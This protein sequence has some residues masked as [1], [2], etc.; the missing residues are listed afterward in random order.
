MFETH[1]VHLLVFAVLAWTRAYVAAKSFERDAD[2]DIDKFSLSA[3]TGTR[4][5]TLG[6][7]LCLLFDKWKYTLA[8]S[9][10]L[11]STTLSGRGLRYKGPKATQIQA[12]HNCTQ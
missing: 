11:P 2:E 5:Q 3:T 1:R 10:L 9:M 4:S 7:L 6:G 8:R 12:P